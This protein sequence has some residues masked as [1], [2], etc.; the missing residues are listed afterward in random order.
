MQCSFSLEIK[1]LIHILKS[2]LK[3]I[4]A[5]DCWGLGGRGHGW[6]IVHFLPVLFLNCLPN[7][8]A[9]VVIRRS[10]LG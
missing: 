2:F 6:G 10:S 8:L 9:L 1:G 5:A 7:H 4:H 3:Q